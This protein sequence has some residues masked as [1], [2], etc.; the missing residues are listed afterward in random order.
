M[1]AYKQT[2]SDHLTVCMYFFVTAAFSAFAFS[3]LTL[4]VGR[5]EGHL[6]CKKHEWW[7]AG[8]VI[9]LERGADLHMAQLMPLPLTFSC[10]SKIQIGFSFLVLA[11]PG[12]PGKRAVKR[13]CV[14][15]GGLAVHRDNQ[16]K[17]LMTLLLNKTQKRAVQGFYLFMVIRHRYCHLSSCLALSW[18]MLEWQATGSVRIQP[19]YYDLHKQLVD[20]VVH[21]CRSLCET[22]GDIA[23]HVQHV[24]S[25]Q[26]QMVSCCR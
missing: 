23:L 22:A 14:C 4:L 8:V 17:M 21:W 26:L 19:R 18:F 3:A 11:H 9:C 20:C 10:F 1:C 7:G 12:S 5:Q 13:V 16:G 25:Q 15:A 2:F 24:T 6:A